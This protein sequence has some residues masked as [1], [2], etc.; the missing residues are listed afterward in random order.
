MV[1]VILA[2]AA[3]SHRQE[4]DYDHHCDHH[5]GYHDNRHESP[6]DSHAQVHGVSCL[7]ERSRRRHQE[8]GDGNQDHGFDD[9]DITWSL[10][11]CLARNWQVLSE[12]FLQFLRLSRSML[13]QCCANVD[14]DES[15][16][17]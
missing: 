16:T 3:D 15:P 13:L 2:M 4:L 14:M 9:L 8:P 17:T 5:C 12:S 11:Q 7:R 6:A 1:N 10:L